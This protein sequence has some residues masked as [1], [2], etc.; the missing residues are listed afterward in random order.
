MMGVR[1]LQGIVVAVGMAFGVGLLCSSTAAAASPGWRIDA[2]SNTRAAPGGT[3]DYLVQVTNVSGADSDGSQLVLVATLPAGVTAVSTANASAGANFS[4]TGPGASVVTC[5]ETDVVPAYDFR[6]LRLTVA[7]DPSAAGP[8]TSSFQVSGGGA[9]SARTVDPMRITATPPGFG[10]DAFDG[11]VTADSDGAPFTQAAGHPFAASTAID[12]NTVTNPNPPFGPLWPVEPTKDVLVELPA[13]FI[14]DPINTAQCTATQ[15]AN[16]QGAEPAPLC[17]ATSQVGTTLVRM[18]GLPGPVVLGPLPL[19]N[20]VPGPDELARFGF[21]VAGTVVTL[22]A[23]LRSGSDYGLTLNASDA[24]QTLSVAGMSLTLWGVPADPSHNVERAC[25]GQLNPWRGGPSCPSGA[26]RR[27]FLRN[28]TSCTAPG[29]GLPTTLNVDSW[30]HPGVFRSATFL[31]HLPPA[32]PLPPSQWGARQGPTGCDTVPF[33]ASVTAAPAS[34]PQAGQPVAFS[35]DVYLPQSDDPD[36]LGEGDLWW[37]AMTLP[38]GVRVSPVGENGFGGCSPAQ[39]ALH[40]TAEPACPDASKIGS[41]TIDTPLLSQPLTG[42]A[43]LAT[44][45]DNPFGSALAIY[46][47]AEGR[48][49]IVKLPWE[50]QEDPDTGELTAISDDFPQLPL[51]HLQLELSGG[52]DAWMALPDACGTFTTYAL[53]AS[54]SERAVASA[55]SFSVS[56]GAGGGPCPTPPPPP[57]PGGTRVA[58]SPPAPIA[59]GSTPQ[60]SVASVGRTRVGD[61]FVLVPLVCSGGGGCSIVATLSV[62]QRVRGGGVV[63]IAAGR[64]RLRTR[65]RVVG[66]ASIHLAAGQRKT[67]RV[68]VNRLGRRLLRRFGKLTATLRVVQDRK[69]VKMRRV[70]LS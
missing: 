46:L 42:S 48:G 17:P 34:T 12:F 10:V 51:S 15:L 4:C 45:N 37:A 24:P 5:T 56:E 1:R 50:V 58:A 2:L 32:Y 22:D 9:A 6:T 61:G 35:F 55:S 23:Q 65:V 60:A 63:G 18:N 30:T 26:Y 69:T 3:L 20:M 38:E 66:R 13:G 57:T 21:D 27:A 11:Q 41:V 52:P 36:V 31:S 16:V 70:R 29:V 40:T 33:H 28:P 67:L 59:P 43:Y 19:F 68:G 49:L 44:P 64:Q 8:V 62:V 7:V 53:A 54:W 47:V 39:I 14:A 25:P